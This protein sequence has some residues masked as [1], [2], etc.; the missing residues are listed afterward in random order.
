MKPVT[1]S[2]FCHVHWCGFFGSPAPHFYNF[3]PGM[4]PRSEVGDFIVASLLIRVMH[5]NSVVI[6]CFLVSQQFQIYALLEPF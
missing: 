2:N 1:Q 3:A 4:K 6:Q 5:V